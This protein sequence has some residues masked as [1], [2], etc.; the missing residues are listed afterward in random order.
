M[1]KMLRRALSFVVVRNDGTTSV[2]ETAFVY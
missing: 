1:K 2:A